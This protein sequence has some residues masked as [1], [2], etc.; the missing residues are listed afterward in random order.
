MRFGADV[1][2]W[3][4]AQVLCTVLYTYCKF[5]LEVCD[6]V[7]ETLAGILLLIVL[8]LA[9]VAVS[10]FGFAG[11]VWVWQKILEN[12]CTALVLLKVVC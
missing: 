4:V 6:L 7:G 8:A 10:K 3:S 9:P 5:Y 12:I 1:A 2:G 11:D